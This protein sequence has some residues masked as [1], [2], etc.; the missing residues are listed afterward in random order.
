[1]P[2]AGYRK[3]KEV[4]AAA[5]M[6]GTI[7]QQIAALLREAVGDAMSLSQAVGISEKEVYGHLDHVRRSAVAS[8]E[9][10]EV[11][12]SECLGCGFRFDDRYRLSRPGRCPRC[13]QGRVS[14][15]AFRIVPR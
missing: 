5:L 15:P 2:R 7:R 3:R 4:T 13:R 14:R 11:L 10:F 12:P 1:M 6:S 9:R 8:G